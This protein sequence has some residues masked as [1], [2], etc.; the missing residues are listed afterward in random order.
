MYSS[1]SASADV[2]VHGCLPDLFFMY[3]CVHVIMGL[4]MYMQQQLTVRACVAYC[5]QRPAGSVC[6]YLYMFIYVTLCD[7]MF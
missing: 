2:V 4:G 6:M 3:G 7:S 5:T 1:L